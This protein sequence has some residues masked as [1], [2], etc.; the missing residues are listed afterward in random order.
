MEP[1]K[2]I[3][4]AGGI[5]QPGWRSLEERDLD[6]TKPEQWGRLFYPD[7]I[8]C[9][10]AEHVWE[11]LT[12]Q[13]ALMAAA[14]CYAYL[15][16]GGNL[17]IAVPDGNHPSPHYLEWVRPGRG[18]NGSDH[19]VLYSYR[20]MGQLLSRVGFDVELREFFDDQRRLHSPKPLNPE[21]GRIQRTFHGYSRTFVG[22][23]VSAFLDTAYTSLIVD[24]R[25]PL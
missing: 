17:R 23:L 10:L 14:N 5:H 4:G 20:T 9:I 24:A 1:L 3:I 18:W 19:K 22:A 2:I 12:P 11:H 15:K 7:S 8:D 16:P 13:E 21:Q 25:K 6:I